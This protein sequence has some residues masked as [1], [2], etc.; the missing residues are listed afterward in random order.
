MNDLLAIAAQNTIVAAFLAILV[1][2]LTRLWQRPPVA[3]ILWLLVLA[4]LIGPPVLHVNVTG[5]LAHRPTIEPRG[6][7][8]ELG[9]AE[10]FRVPRTQFASLRGSVSQS[11]ERDNPIASAKAEPG[12]ATSAEAQP[13]TFENIFTSSTIFIRR[14]GNEALAALFVAWIAG[15]A[16]CAAVALW[17]I[18]RF[19]RMI[20]QTLAA[21]QRLQTIAADL[22]RKLGLRCVPDIRL[23][24]GVAIP[25]VWCVGRG[26]IIALPARLS[27]QL[28]EQQTSMVLAHELAHLKRRDHWVRDVELVISL[29][30]WWNPPGLV[31]PPQAARTRRT[32]LRR[33]GRLGLSRQQEMLRRSTAQSGH[34]RRTGASPHA[35]TGQFLPESRWPEGANRSGARQPSAS[36]GFPGRGPPAWSRCHRIP[37]VRRPVRQPG[38][39]STSVDIASTRQ[40]R[41][42][43]IHR[44][45]AR[46]DR[47]QGHRERNR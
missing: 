16:F 22:A 12:A 31:G 18:I 37:A 33:L 21:P 46:K 32:V 26:P 40:A 5:L 34:R 6:G 14:H 25:L 7:G 44:C 28:D 2:G 29:I 9:A 43:S 3:H 20:L 1:Y 4:K 30:Y 47:W 19:N 17:R 13:T 45:G 41:P 24:E 23:V 39:R 38:G 10:R 27:S 15:L 8:L 42:C 36:P 11:P 35:G